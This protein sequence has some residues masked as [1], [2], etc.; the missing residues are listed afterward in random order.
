[1][2]MINVVNIMQRI[3]DIV[4]NGFMGPEEIATELANGY[5]RRE[6]RSK[7]KSEEVF[8]SSK[9]FFDRLI[10][11]WVKEKRGEYLRDNRTLPRAHK[12]AGFMDCDELSD[13]W[14]RCFLTN[15]F[16]TSPLY[17][18]AQPG[19]TSPF[20]FEKHAS[21][22]NVARVYMIGLSG[23]KS[24]DVRRIVVTERVPIL[25]PVYNMSAAA[26]EQLWDSDR[27][28]VSVEQSDISKTLTEIVVDDLCGLYQ[29]VAKFDK[30]PIKGCAVVRNVTYQVPN[31]PRDNVRGV[32]SE[33]LG[34]NKTMNV[35]HGGFYILLNPDSEAMNK[36]EH[37]LYFKAL[38]VNYEVEAKVHIGMLAA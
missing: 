23:F 9:L 14:W 1:M 15:P 10:E 29:M 37:L 2:K 18:P 7:E 26:E 12:V 33:R 25:I 27:H 21:D 34:I 24:P 38:S 8:V 36:G 13:E 30:K 35:C 5:Q 6:K 31:I 16:E 4:N 3:Q 19:F 32:P 17:A 28:A 20:L 11:D 22:I